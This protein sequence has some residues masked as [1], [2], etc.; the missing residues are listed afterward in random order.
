MDRFHNCST[1][2]SGNGF[3]SRE[4]VLLPVSDS[5]DE[6]KNL[7]LAPLQSAY[8][9]ED[10]IQSFK[11]T[12][13]VFFKNPALEEKYNAFRAKRREAG[14][15]AEEL[16]ETY[17]FLLFDDVNK[18]NALGETGVLSGN[19]ACTTL[20]D[21]SKGVYISMYSDCLELNRWYHGKSG[22]IAIIRLTKGRVKK[23]SENYTQNFTAPTPGFDCHV[24]EQLSAI[25]AKTSCFLAFERTQ[26]YMY[27]LLEDGSNDT[28]LSPSAACPF[29]IVSF[30]YTDTQATVVIP[31][32]ISEEK[33]SRC[34]YLPWRGQLQI[35][36]QL[37]NVGLRSTP[38]ALV[39]GKLPPVV[40]VDQAISML[41]LRQLLPQAVFETCFSSEVFLDGLYCS[42]CE[43]VPSET[44]GSSSLSVLLQEIKEKD[45]ALPVLLN[46]GGFL[47][48][49]H[50]SYFLTYDDA[51]S[52][53][54]EGLQALFV[55]PQSR[56]VQR[57]TKF[58]GIKA[59]MSPEILRVLPAL[60]Y[61]E[62]EVEKTTIDPSEELCEVLVRHMHSYAALLNPAQP[63]SPS[64]EVSA[65]P[66]QYDVPDAHK[67]LYSSPEWTPRTWQIF[68]SY[69][70][71]P[72]SFQLPVF[73]ASEIL[74]A[75]QDG[76]KEDFDDD[77]YICL[78]SPE[79]P[80]PK[81]V[82]IESE[83]ELTVYKSVNVETV[84]DNC[85]TS[86][87]AQDDQTALPQN[88]S[89]NWLAECLTKDNEISDLTAMIKKDMA[90][91]NLLNLPTSEDLPTELIVSITSAKRT[92][93]EES[94]VG[95]SNARKRNDFELSDFS[96]T[97]L[98]T[99]GVNSLNDEALN[100]INGDCT[101][102]SNLRKTKRRKRSRRHFR[103]QKK[104][105][106]PAIETP[107]L[108][109]ENDTSMSQK[110]DVAMQ[111]SGH[112]EL[113]NPSNI[114]WRK[115]RRRKRIFCKLSSK[116]KKLRS[117]AISVVSD[118]R[119]Q[120]LESTM[121]LQVF[122]FRKKT[123]RWDLKPVVSECGRLLVPHGSSDFA[124]HIK[125]LKHKLSKKCTKH[126]QCPEKVVN[127]SVNA[128][129][130]SV[131]G[132]DTAEMEQESNT[133]LETAVE[134]T[135]S[136]SLIDGVNHLN[137]NV[138]NGPEHC[139]WRQPNNNEASLP[140][141][142]EISKDSL[143]ND[144]TDTASSEVPNENHTNSL[145]PAK[146]PSKGKFLL[147]KLKS[148]LLRGKRKRD[149]VSEGSIT[150]TAQDIEPRLKK[151]KGDSELLKSNNAVAS[152]QDTNEGV[153]EVSKMLSLD[154]VFAR[155]L[156]LTPKEKPDK[157]Q[158][159][160]GPEAELKKDSSETQEHTILEQQT[161]ITETPPLNF[162]KRSRIKTLKKHHGIPTE[163]IKKKWW[164]HFQTP[165]CFATEKEKCKEYT[166]EKSVRKTVK[167][168]MNNASASTDAL[169]LLAD[170]A[171][172][173]SH[174]KVPLQPDSSLEREP[175]TSLKKCDL[176]KDVT[177]AEQESVLHALLR[178]PAARPILESPP[179][180]NLVGGTKLI[181]LI[182]KEHAYSLPTSSSLLLGLPGTPFQVS[183]LSGSTRL[184]HHYQQLYGIGIQ[185]LHPAIYQEDGSE[186]N[187]RTTE[188]LLKHVVHRQKFR[189]S[190]TF[191]NKNDSIQVTRQ[192]KDNY[193]FNLDSKFTSD[194][195]DRA[196]IRALHG[197][198]DFSVQD[199]SEEVQLIVHMWIGLFYSR[200][201]A[202]FFHIDP[203]FKYP[204]FKE[205]DSLDVFTGMPSTPAHSELMATSSAP[206][207]IVTHTS[208]A[209]IT[210]ALDLSKKDNSVLG[211]GAV[212]LDLSLR[213]L[214]GETHSSGPQVKTF[215]VLIGLQEASTFQCYTEMVQSTESIHK[216]ED[217]TS[218]NEN[219]KMYTP[220]QK[221]GC[222]RI[223]DVPSFKGNGSLIP[224]REEAESVPIGPK[225]LVTA[226]EKDHV[227]CGSNKEE[228]GRK[229]G[230]EN[231][232]S[233]EM[234][235]SQK[236]KRDS[237]KS[238]TDEE[239]E[240]IKEMEE[241]PH[242]T[243]YREIESKDEANSEVKENPYKEDNIEPPK[244]IDL[245]DDA[246]KEELNTVYNGKCLENDDH[247]S[248]EEPKT[249][250]PAQIDS[251]DVDV[252]CFAVDED[253][254]TKDEDHLGKEDGLNE[255]DGCIS[256]VEAL[257]NFTDETLLV[258]C[259]APDSSKDCITDCSQQA[260]SDNQ[261][262]QPDSENDACHD[263]QLRKLSGNVFTDEHSTSEKF[264][265]VSEMQPVYSEPLVK[266][267][268]EK[269]CLAN[270]AASLRCNESTCSL[271][272]SYA[273]ESVPK[274]SAELENPHM[275]KS[276][277]GFGLSSDQ[278][279]KS[280]E[281]GK[282]DDATA[283]KGPFHSQSYSS[284][285][286]IIKKGEALAKETNI[287]MDKT[288]E[289]FEKS[290]RGIVIPFIGM[291]ISGENLVHPH[292]SQQKSKVVKCVQG[293]H[294]I[295]FISETSC[296]V[297][298]TDVCSAS[299]VNS[300]NTELSASKISLS[301]LNETNQ[302]VVVGSASDERCPTP[303]LDEEPYEYVLDSGPTNCKNITEK[304]SST[305][306]TTI[307][308]EIPHEQNYCHQSAV[309]GKPSTDCGLPSDFELS[310]LGVLQSIEKLFSK[311]N[312]NNKSNQMDA[313]TKHCL[314]Q[315]PNFTSKHIPV[316]LSLKHTLTNF[317]CK[318][319]GQTKS[320]VASAS[321]S[322]PHTGSSEHFVFSPFKTKLEEVLG[323]KLQLKKTDSSVSH[324]F[325]TTETFQQISVGEDCHSYTSFPSECFQ[326]IKPIINND[327]HKALQS[328]LNP[329]LHL[330]SS[331]PV[332]AVKPSKSDESQA[333]SIYKDGRVEN[334]PISKHS[335]TPSVTYTTHTSMENTES[336]KGNPEGLNG[337]KHKASEVSSRS[338]SKSNL[339]D[340]KFACLDP[341]YHCQQRDNSKFNMGTSSSQS[342]Q[343]VES[344]HRSCTFDDGKQGYLTCSLVDKMG[345][346]TK[347]K[348]NCSDPSTSFVDYKSL[349]IMDDH[350]SLGPD[351]SL[352]YTVHNTSQKRK[353]NYLDHVSKRCIQNDLTQATV[354]W[355]H[356]IFYDQMKQ[357]LKRS[358]RGPI[359]QQ[360]AHN[361]LKCSCAEPITVDFSNLEEPEDSLDNLDVPSLLRQ[362]INVDMSERKDL[363]QTKE[364]EK[365]LDTGGTGTPVEHVEVSDVTEECAR[366]YEAMMNDVCAV[367]KVPS[368]SKH[369]RMDRGNLKTEP[370]NNF[371]FCDQMKREMDESFYTNLNSVVRKS[372][373][374]K[375][376]FYILET[377]DD[378]FFEETRAQL[379]K[380][381]HIAVQPDEFF[382]GEE[383]SSLIIILK[384]EDI[385]EHICEVPQLLELKKAPGVQF[386]G[387]DEPDDV[388]NLTHQ[389]L[390][391]RGGFVMFDRTA[392]ESLSLCS[393]KKS[394]DILQELCETGK[395][396]WMLHYRDSRRLK[397]K[398]RLS[399]EAKEKTHFLNWCQD[400]G[401]LEVLPYHECDLM[402][403]DQPDYLTCLVS[404][405]VQN[406]SARY[407]LFI[408]DTKLDSAFGR[409]GILT[410]SVDSYLKMSPG[411]T[412]A[413]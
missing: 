21:P 411:E 154:P 108:P 335:K 244:V 365:T 92:V 383:T 267:D 19:N 208:D 98:Q 351:T 279:N 253:K 310:T 285:F 12:S 172:S 174:D 29:A 213:N 301:D 75:G 11:Y 57:D 204:C 402:S 294:K 410:M 90:G 212:I 32:E 338:D 319:I 124:D 162:A 191:F 366:L 353:Y 391:T 305:K 33:K 348:V 291:D 113:S 222:L 111:S 225:S 226:S 184:L 394:L 368:R 69:L 369:I 43:L 6:F 88:V 268:L 112:L 273:A 408:T 355:E 409:N 207:P 190:R 99:A 404:L 306:A 277:F 65:F 136:T 101:E 48:L 149:L 192:W 169:N 25:S 182:S 46:D 170:L 151:G 177:S 216:V 70:S 56:L 328:S 371:D 1:M 324:S 315:T 379:E 266:K 144:A 122:P 403:K 183:P 331:R 39:T 41:D 135:E 89:H 400:A 288:K 327:R 401:I 246:T 103:P 77:V 42:L 178:K 343:S 146:C 10:S 360:D 211:Q 74:A 397:E 17:G 171:L 326:A 286:E 123:E 382:T 339:D 9:Y 392:L 5:S 385:A 139:F 148:V 195:K 341:L 309:N 363:A 155:A 147:S 137:Q 23:V 217:T 258:K 55:F 390:F 186:H 381:G 34:H 24:S 114:P 117:A 202:R 160:E 166:R 157:M 159:T 164:L 349:N 102:V 393:M 84:V 18:A 7:I 206:T 272:G 132:H 36:T 62:A 181:D 388:I 125:C 345:Q 334:L 269:D 287:K 14:Y 307:K 250:S 275:E 384:N 203:N 91:K 50:S 22:Y 15:S 262:P 317:K 205:N 312:H 223:I 78:S 350:L 313:D 373:K 243:E 372:C 270:K 138:V 150:N 53:T 179:P 73:K 346:T 280:T 173:A 325:E 265:T 47:I 297:L 200:S 97:K 380:Q 256:S 85:L 188:Y 37:Y 362:K 342:M 81:S 304:C 167:E 239:M 130:T 284:Q 224:L 189:H 413:A 354:E 210:K 289:G 399:A 276:D 59:A 66:D 298:P 406:I 4:G 28:A 337:D 20:G 376:R 185:T 358:K 405:Q 44:E 237:S 257:T 247:L 199:T 79:E 180:C 120:N 214:N 398:A 282:N 395:W 115:L 314:N 271:D 127:S 248:G 8:L 407:T 230:I 259:D 110:D 104:A 378:A 95:I 145:S 82:G 196:I 215:Q 233:T 220:F 209:S 133:A 229:D 153:K 374:T 303:T 281:A 61:A 83:D 93:T 35:G 3:V 295:P 116:N 134:K 300:K 238:V 227:L 389:E 347:E 175:E 31:Q 318:K 54:K 13:A 16:K 63:L 228:T 131:N 254:M 40:K 201:T 251:V 52:Y 221:A 109:V 321:T 152:D 67:H 396:K 45:L 121:E 165:A 274:D 118:P 320:V 126:E 26:Y 336:L 143:K 168:K 161:Q 375:Y 241:V 176:T 106:K 356:L 359:G 249:F 71:K 361:K 333:G 283:G 340:V 105:S 218:I 323:V 330:H 141:N 412:F 263:L 357:L 296:P 255:K 86:A 80:L 107:S 96:A 140:L 352:K 232:G 344:T 332:M 198:W 100:I 72:F 242:T 64:R 158:K 261:L 30:A 231:S 386:A 193:D 58:G 194:P 278:E 51:G 308:D 370:C 316:C 235:L 234:S 219:E 142:L 60:S 38:M 299:Q 264:Q 260:P 87:G 290:P 68:K 128:F 2:E 364:E 94:L 377:S 311:S 293:Q 27:E 322:Q 156:G 119:Q 292:V 76:Q 367:K 387:I 236:L 329:E 187:N 129:D 49:L 245:C 197:P 302:P 163:F 252:D 240:S